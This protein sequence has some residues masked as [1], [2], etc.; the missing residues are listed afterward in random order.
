MKLFTM[1]AMQAHACPEFSVHGLFFLNLSWSY[2]TH[3]WSILSEPK[4]VLILILWTFDMYQ[5]AKECPSHLWE[6]WW[7]KDGIKL[8]FF[9]CW[10]CVFCELFV[11]VCSVHNART[12]SKHCQHDF[13]LKKPSILSI[14]C[15]HSFNAHFGFLYLFSKL[16]DSI[17]SAKVTLIFQLIKTPASTNKSKTQ[18]TWKM[19]FL[20]DFCK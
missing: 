3:F 4:L 10:F 1:H 11:Q 5:E 14:F 16:E 15:S 8:F 6:I 7:R 12:R 2:L 9:S 19:P 18:A 17:T 20:W 13:C